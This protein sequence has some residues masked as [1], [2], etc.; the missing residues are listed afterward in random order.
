[1]LSLKIQR[2]FMSHALSSTIKNRVQLTVK[3]SEDENNAKLKMI[4]TV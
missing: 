4:A 1:M 3:S 2:Y